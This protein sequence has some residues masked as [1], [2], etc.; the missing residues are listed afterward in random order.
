MRGITDDE[1]PPLRRLPTLQL[2]DRVV[3]PD[4]DALRVRSH[5]LH[6]RL[7][8]IIPAVLGGRHHLHQLRLVG[9]E[10]RPA[11]PVQRGVRSL[12]ADEALA[13]VDVLGCDDEGARLAL[14][15]RGKGVVGSRHAERVGGD[16]GGD[17]QQAA[18]LGLG[19]VRVAV[20]GDVAAHA[21]VD[22]IAADES[23][24]VELLAV[25]QCEQH[26]RGAVFGDDVRVLALVVDGDVTFLDH[27]R[28]LVD[29]NLPVDTEAA[30][31]VEL[32]V[33]EV[34]DVF[35]L[36]LLIEKGQL[37]EVEAFGRD[38]LEDGLRV[39]AQVVEHAERVWAKHDG[40][41]EVVTAF[42]RL[43]DFDFD[44]AIV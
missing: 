8:Q 13:A 36:V 25:G 37:V 5:F 41:T 17:G 4:V 10:V 27:V 34:I 40:A 38:T 12:R 15:G 16:V 21:R 26:T 9:S 6:G 19:R 42:P 14:H 11:L 30:V 31:A 44:V 29:E 18:E 33:S 22:A 20:A 43:V 7:D 32:L 2:G 28:H 1:D 39:S 35:E 3:G 24:R 23:V